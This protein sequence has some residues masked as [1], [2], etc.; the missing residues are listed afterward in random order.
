MFQ[1]PSFD[2]YAFLCANLHHFLN[3]CREL[4]DIY[5]Q[6]FE[7]VFQPIS[8][9]DFILKFT[10]FQVYYRLVVLFFQKCV[11]VCVFSVHM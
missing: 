4:D 9:D 1:H 6:Q 2:K 8:L 5:D 3:E 10:P 7:A 11:C